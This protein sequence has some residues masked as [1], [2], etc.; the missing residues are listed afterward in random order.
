MSCLVAGAVFVLAW[1]FL[2]PMAVMLRAA[3]EAYRET[4]E[5]LDLSDLDGITKRNLEALR[6]GRG[7]G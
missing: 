6:A 7:L 1:W 4:R 3:W 5:P 2:S